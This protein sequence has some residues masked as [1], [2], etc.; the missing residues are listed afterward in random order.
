MSSRDDILTAGRDHG[1]A[2]APLRRYPTS[3][4]PQPI[5][6]ACSRAH[7]PTGWQGDSRAPADLPAWLATAFPDARRICSAAREVSGNVDPA[8]LEDWAAPADVD[9]TVL[10]TPLSVAETGPSWSARKRSPSPPSRCSHDTVSCCS[11]PPTSSRTSTLPTDTPPSEKPPTRFC[12]RDH[13]GPPRSVAS[14]SIQP[15]ASP[16]SPSCSGRIQVRQRQGKSDLN[17]GVR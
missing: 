11:I 13:H 10:R 1:P 8:G 4:A 17:P 16:P 2:S 7:C 9:V 12:C 15:K 3:A 5:S 6:S 14:P